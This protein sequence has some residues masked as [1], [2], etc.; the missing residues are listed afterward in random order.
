MILIFIILAGL[1]INQPRHIFPIR[2]HMFPSKD[3]DQHL[4]PVGL[5]KKKKK[6]KKKNEEA[7]RTGHRV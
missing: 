1:K 3:S 6:K 5:K 7:G 4:T 2:L